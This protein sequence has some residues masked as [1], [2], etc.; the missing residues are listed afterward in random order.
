[1]DKNNFIISEQIKLLYE[2][3]LSAAI[4]IIVISW[5][6][7]LGLNSVIDNS[8]LIAWVVLMHLV[9]VHRIYLKKHFLN[10][11]SPSEL[12]LL[13][14]KF[15]ANT[16]VAGIGWGIL[17][18]S[19]IIIEEELYQ[20]AIVL[21]SLGVLGTSVPLLSSYLPAFFTSS[22]PAAILL[23]GIIYSNMGDVA[24]ILTL[25]IFLFIL[26]IYKTSIKSNR[27]MKSM[28][29]LQYDN[30]SLIDTLNGEITERQLFQEKLECHQKNLESLVGRSRYAAEKHRSHHPCIISR[31]NTGSYLK[32]TIP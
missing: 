13:S 7:L 17:S 22:M 9:A 32:E 23:P 24:N 10:M 6:I 1:M 15:V 18:L 4:G 26:L 12:P 16:A 8:Y 14:K 3:S 19:I 31:P 30:H 25:A 20:T 27:N 2:N 29:A 5:A 21:I 11:A 28:F